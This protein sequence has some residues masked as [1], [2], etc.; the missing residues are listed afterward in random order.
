[1]RRVDSGV[2]ELHTLF[3]ERDRQHTG[4]SVE[5]RPADGDRTVAVPF[6]LHDCAHLRRRDQIGERAHIGP[7]GAEV[8]LGPHRPVRRA[9]HVVRA[10]NRTMSARVTIP[11]TLPSFSTTGTLLTFRSCMSV[12]TSSSVASG[13]TVGGASSI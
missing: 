9:A 6:R 4:T 5:C 8:D 13:P 10:M 11:T 2:A 1:D 12:A 7:Y 3:D